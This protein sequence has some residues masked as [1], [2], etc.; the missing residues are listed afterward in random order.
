MMGMREK[1]RQ[2]GFALFNVVVTH[3]PSHTIRLA[4]L[5]AW[6]AQIGARSTIGRGTT[7]IDIDGLRV[8]EGCSIGF[9]CM[10][11]ARGGIRIADDVTIAS[12][13][14]IITGR[15]EVHSDSFAAVFAPVV[16]GDHVWIA[17]RSTIVDGVTIGRG[18]VVGACTLVRKDVAEME[19]VAG[20]PARSLGTRTSSLNYT[21]AYRRKFY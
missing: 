8:G 13:T 1:W 19:I 17:S 10:L 2:V 16:I 3:I 11:D 20:V 18:A 14:H 5:R 21:A 7:I 6:G 12:D 9:R 15:H 4:T